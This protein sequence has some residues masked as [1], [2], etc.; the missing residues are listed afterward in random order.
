ML[1]LLKYSFCTWHAA[2]I[3]QVVRKPEA[4]IISPTLLIFVENQ[5]HYLIP[6]TGLTASCGVVSFKCVCMKDIRAFLKAY[7]GDI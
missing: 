5:M 6:T 1:P 7:F 4:D 3:E 2:L